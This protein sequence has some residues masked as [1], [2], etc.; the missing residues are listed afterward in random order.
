[1]VVGASV[2]DVI[3]KLVWNVYMLNTTAIAKSERA[4][5]RERECVSLSTAHLI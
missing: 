1:M 2:V 3:G 4:S 5:E